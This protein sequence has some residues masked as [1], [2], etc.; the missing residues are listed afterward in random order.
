MII[1]KMAVSLDLPY[2][3]LWNLVTLG[4][5]TA[6]IEVQQAM[7]RI[8]YWQNQVLVGK[9][10]DRVRQKVIAQG[11]ARQE[12]PPHPLWRKC[13]WHFGLSI[14]TDVA[15]EAES[16][17]AMVSAGIRS[18]SDVTG[19]YGNSPREVFLSNAT[20]ANE[21]IQV[22]AETEVPVEVFARGL[23]PDITNQKAAMV[24]GP[25]PPP[26]PG[27]AE[28]LGDKNVKTLLDL[29]KAVGEGKMDRDAAIQTLKRTFGVP[30]AMA[31]QMVPEEPDKAKLKL[32]NPS[33]ANGDRSKPAKVKSV[34]RSK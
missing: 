7:R 14:Q 21:A 12:L 4:G 2:G 18:I 26:E 5:V 24:T 19:K 10:L 20:T 15:Y 17:I 13:E 34:S 16:D 29:L 3:F 31:D 30:E 9:I 8:E 22:G 25:V 28:A 11:I 23:F 27:S 1:R 6:R 32:L 33:S